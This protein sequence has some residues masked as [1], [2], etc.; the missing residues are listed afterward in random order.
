MRCSNR[1][2]ALHCWLTLLAV[3]VSVI[4]SGCC[5]NRTCKTGV[6]GHGGCCNDLT[7]ETCCGDCGGEFDLGC[8]GC[9][10]CDSGYEQLGGCNECSPGA[11]PGSCGS[12]VRGGCGGIS[13]LFLPL[14]STKLACGTSGGCGGIYWGEWMSDP[15]ACCDP[16]NDCGCW[17]ESR[18]CRHCGHLGNF[19][20]HMKRKVHH[21]FHAGI[22]GYYPQGCNSCG[23]Q[24]CS[25]CNDC[26]SCGGCDSCGDGFDTYDE[27]MDGNSVTH[28]AAHQAG[29]SQG[30]PPHR[31]VS[32]RLRRSMK[33][34]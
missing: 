8:D 34:Q 1:T 20:G 32:R 22:Y 26:G 30:R 11:F 29:F 6:F 24:G 13:G 9:A 17:V 33:D 21:V 5:I 2:Q 19:W 25:S 18:G 7:T 27:V 23:D 12:C 4:S 28:P 31:V 3:T 10:D 15:P 16:C 14:L